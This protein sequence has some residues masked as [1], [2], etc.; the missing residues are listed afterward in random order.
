MNKKKVT[1]FAIDMDDETKKQFD[2]CCNEDFVISASLMP[3]A[4]NGYVAPIGSVF[5]VKDKVVPAWVGYDI[6]CGMIACVFKSKNIVEEIRLH[7]DEIFEKVNDFVPMGTG[8]IGSHGDVSSS[9][10]ARFKAILESF[11]QKEYDDSI[12]KFLKTQASSHLGS[13]GSGNHFIDLGFNEGN[14]DELWLI[15]HSGSRGVGHKVATHYMKS[16]SNFDKDYE[17]TYSLD[18]ES[19]EGKQYLNVL[20]FGL[21]FAL[22]NRL[23]MAFRVQKALREI[24]ND[25][26][27]KY[28]LWVNKNHNHAI[29]LGGS[30]MIGENIYVHRKGATPA[31]LGERGVIPAN[32]R[33]GCYLVQ[34][35]GN[36]EFLNSSSHGAGRKLSRKSAKQTINIEDFE[37]SMK[38]IIGKVD[39]STLDE[40]PQ[41]YKN[42][43]DVMNAQKDSVKVISH[44]I[45]IINWKG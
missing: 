34:G 19:D 16:A 14:N 21:E 6:G 11:S 36:I 13:L 43:S 15:I 18:I 29:K 2:S 32:M 10:K 3:D 7:A 41:A 30:H 39:E 4:H 44:I 27:L 26:D 33:D 1:N 9:I 17:K 22:L 12:F 35:L 45:P 23:E 8:M 28:T 24:L 20:N 40:A 31:N 37:E 5:H 42:I 38:G 25:N